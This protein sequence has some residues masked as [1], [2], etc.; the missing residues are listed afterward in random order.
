[1]T[2]SKSR[3]AFRA[4]KAPSQR[5]LRVG[6]ELRHA[7]AD[8][9]RRGDFRDPGLQNLNV[10]VTEV[11]VSP[12]LSAATVFVTPLGGGDMDEALTILKRGAPSLRAQVAHAVL[13][14]HVPTLSFEAD[15][16]FEYANR[17]ATI[18]HRPDV[19][20]DLGDDFARRLG[21]RVEADIHDDED[22]DEDQEDEDQE[23]EHQ[24]DEDEDEDQEGKSG[25][26]A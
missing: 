1:M 8:L 23:D 9:L 10:T 11:R 5:Q 14:R 25:P 2:N 21:D 4:G 24:E 18:L 17:I 15:T 3:G 20:R 13:L 7:L 12:N 6:E 16:S 19:A 22:G 26:Q